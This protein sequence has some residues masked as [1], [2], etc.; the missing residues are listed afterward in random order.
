MKRAVTLVAIV[1][2]GIGVKA[3]VSGG[4][5]GG[6]STGSVEIS[7]LDQAFTGVIEGKNIRGWEAGLYLKAKAGPVFVKPMALY[8]FRKGDVTYTPSGSETSTTGS[9]TMHKVAV[10]LLLGFHLLGPLVVEGGPVFN[11]LVAVTEDYGT[12]TVNLGNSALGY[13]VGVGADFDRLLLS[14]H[15]Q[16]TANYKA[17]SNQASFREPYQ[18]TFGL[19]IR[20]GE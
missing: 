6:V 16:G 5:A 4:L 14:L 11:Y 20:L 17:N 10:P 12:S 8:N 13:R 15:Y 3:Q 1:I 19:G 2:S 18:V 7:H 9:F